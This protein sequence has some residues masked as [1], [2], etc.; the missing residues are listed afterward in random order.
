MLIAKLLKKEENKDLMYQI[1]THLLILMDHQDPLGHQDL[2]DYLLFVDLKETLHLMIR[3]LL[4]SLQLNPR[5][6][7]E[8]KPTK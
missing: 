5:E 8:E 1:E 3:Q 4:R 7:L 6:F 2:Q